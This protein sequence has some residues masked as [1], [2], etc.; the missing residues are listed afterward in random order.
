MAIIDDIS[1]LARGLDA[2]LQLRSAIAKA[3]ATLESPSIEF[4]DDS[5]SV[6]VENLLVS[7]SQH[8]RQKNSE[9]T[10][11]RMKSRLN[12]GY[13]VFQAPVGYR[14][15][16]TSGQGKILVRDEP[17]AS[18][19]QEALEG[20]AAGR[21]QLQVEVK[22][23]LE[24]FPEYPKDRKG[25]VRN[26]RVIELLTRVLYAGYV[27]S[28]DWQVSLRPWRHE[29]LISLEAYKDRATVRSHRRCGI[30]C[31]GQRL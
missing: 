11:N 17:V 13:W 3:G 20:Y 5:D 26:Q 25:E 9:Q 23:F 27:E 21:F 28:D 14:Y 6:L 15:Q 30:E 24:S 22:R 31:R 7:V 29:E 10:L 2:H 19:I 4:G 18:I 16:K 12:N 1:R 8:Q